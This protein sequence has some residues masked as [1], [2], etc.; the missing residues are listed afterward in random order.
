MHNR[1]NPPHGKND[2]PQCTP[3]HVTDPAAY[4]DIIY[5]VEDIITERMA[6]ST[7]NDG[8]GLTKMIILGSRLNI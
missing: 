2:V 5:L 7:K 6:K 3:K 8:K 4:D 1:W